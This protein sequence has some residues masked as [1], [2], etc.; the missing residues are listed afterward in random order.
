MNTAI[1]INNQVNTIKRC[2]YV[3]SMHNRFVVA[4]KRT[5]FLW[6]VIVLTLVAQA[7]LCLCSLH[8]GCFW[9]ASKQ[10]EAAA[11]V[12]AHVKWFFSSPYAAIMAGRRVKGTTVA[13]HAGKHGLWVTLAMTLAALEVLILEVARVRWQ[14]LQLCIVTNLWGISSGQTST[15]GELLIVFCSFFPLKFE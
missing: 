10:R 3:S 14:L 9:K 4:G 15:G 12:S 13:K 7:A 5:W 2:R 11:T 6:W 1:W 8:V